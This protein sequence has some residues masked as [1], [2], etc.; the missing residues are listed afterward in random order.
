MKLKASDK[1]SVSK[2]L[3]KQLA[4]QFRARAKDLKKELNQKPSVASNLLQ[5]AEL[6]QDAGAGY[7]PDHTFPQT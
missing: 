2:P 5:P 1:A 6:D 3:L 7:N 4:D